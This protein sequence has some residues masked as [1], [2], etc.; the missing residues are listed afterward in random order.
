MIS[1]VLEHIHNCVNKD[2]AVTVQYY[3]VLCMYVRLWSLPAPNPRAAEAG[4]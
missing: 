4:S 1:N 2:C 3:G